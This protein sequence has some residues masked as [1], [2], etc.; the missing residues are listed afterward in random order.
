MIP[1][2]NASGELPPG[3]H[4]A[5]LEEVEAVFATTPRRRTLFAGL[6]RAVHN[7]RAAGVRHVFIDGSFIT[8]KADPN[9]RKI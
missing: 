1:P 5:S 6:Q 3:I 2:P 9:G 7:L 4:R 8:T